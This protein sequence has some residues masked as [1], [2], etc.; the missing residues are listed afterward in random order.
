MEWDTG[1]AQAGLC[2]RS[3]QVPQ[4]PDLSI[5]V[6]EKTNFFHIRLSAGLPG[7]HGLEPLGSK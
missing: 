1:F 4:V 7:F 6:T 5:W 3:A 2:S